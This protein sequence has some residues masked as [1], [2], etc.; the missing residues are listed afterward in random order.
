MM[1]GVATSEDGQHHGKERCGA[2]AFE[3]WLLDLLPHGLEHAA[4]LNL[5]CLS[6]YKFRAYPK[7]GDGAWCRDWCEFVVCFQR[8][9]VAELLGLTG[10]V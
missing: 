4:I 2:G 8:R 9:A 7:E 3:V 1:T 6:C 5:L 10:S